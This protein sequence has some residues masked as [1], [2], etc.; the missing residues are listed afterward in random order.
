MRFSELLKSKKFND[1]ITVRCI[2]F[3]IVFIILLLIVNLLFFSFY[4]ISKPN[5]KQEAFENRDQI[6]RAMSSQIAQK[7]GFQISRLNEESRIMLP[8]AGAQDQANQVRTKSVLTFS[9]FA[10]L[11]TENWT[12]APARY[13]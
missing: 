10:Y 12:A 6:F 4:S 8:L 1:Y 13:D 5:I 7:I 3:Q 9:K 2:S 11:K